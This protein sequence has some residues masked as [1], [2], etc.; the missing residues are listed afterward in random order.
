LLIELE[1]IALNSDDRKR[2][3][4]EIVLILLVD[5]VVQFRMEAYRLGHCF[6]RP[7]FAGHVGLKGIQEDRMGCHLEVL[8]A[9]CA[10]LASAFLR[11][12]F[13]EASEGHP[14]VRILEAAFRPLNA[15]FPASIRLGDVRLLACCILRTVLS[16]FEPVVV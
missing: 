12:S 3:Y 7:S 13:H 8:S 5:A 9:A 1:G 2:K 15:V 14:S 6:H 10:C 16:S 11:P 4:A